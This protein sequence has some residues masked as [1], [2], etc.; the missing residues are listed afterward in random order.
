[1]KGHPPAENRAVAKFLEFL[2][3]TEQQAWWHA[4]TGYLPVSTA[5]LE[6]LKKAGHFEK[7]PDMWTAFAQITSGRTTPNSQGIR[8]GDFVAIRDVIETELE[9]VLAGKKTA[10]QGLDHAVARGNGILK[11]FAALYK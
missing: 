4:T 7:N 10:R 1:M 3:R 8:L 9:N 2:T 5:A 6:Q 11:E